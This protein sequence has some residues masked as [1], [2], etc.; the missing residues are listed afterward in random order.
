MISNVQHFRM[1]NGCKTSSLV[2]FQGFF[3]GTEADFDDLC[4]SIQKQLIAKQHTPMFEL[5]RE[6]LMTFG[7]RT[8]TVAAAT[9][10]YT[11]ISTTSH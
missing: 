2:N 9:G 1:V 11:T 7:T 4:H 8:T 3:C 10:N 5:L 6:R